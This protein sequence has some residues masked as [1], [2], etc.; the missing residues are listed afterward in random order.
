MLHNKEQNKDISVSR[1][2]KIC[3]VLRKYFNFN[4]ITLLIISI[5]YSF[6]G[7]KRDFIPVQTWPEA[8]RI[9]GVEVAGVARITSCKHQLLRHLLCAGVENL[10]ISLR[11]LG[12][13]ICF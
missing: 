11:G 12:E 1:I 13:N 7:I 6:C 3:T 2:N 10:T 9:R 4:L 5:I 8:A